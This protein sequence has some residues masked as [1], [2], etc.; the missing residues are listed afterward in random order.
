MP[1]FLVTVSFTVTIDE[2]TA[3]LAQQRVNE[4]ALSALG[5]IGVTCVWG[6]EPQKLE[7]EPCP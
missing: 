6:S 7:E 4:R 2:E 5:S 1:E 3:E